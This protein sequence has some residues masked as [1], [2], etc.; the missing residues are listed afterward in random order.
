MKSKSDIDIK[1][2]IGMKNLLFNFTWE[3]IICDE[4]H[5]FRNIKSLLFKCLQLLKGKYKWCFTGTPIVNY[6]NDLISQFVFLGLTPEYR[7]KNQFEIYYPILSNYVNHK[8]YTDC[9][10]VLP[11]VEYNQQVVKLSYEEREFYNLYFKYARDNYKFL[12]KNDQFEHIFSIIMRLRQI[13]ISSYLIL[14]KDQENNKEKPKYLIE[15]D[16]T[17]IG[18]ENI[19]HSNTFD[20]FF[21][22]NSSIMYECPNLNS[23]TLNLNQYKSMNKIDEQIK[24]SINSNSN[25]SNWLNSVDSSAG[26]NSS[27]IKQVIDIVKNKVPKTEKILIFSMFKSVTELFFHAFE[28]NCPEIN[29][30]LFNGDQSLDERNYTINLFKEDPTYRV[31]F[32]TYQTG[33]EGLNIFQANN[34]ILLEG[35]WN[36]SV[37]NQA[38]ARCHRLGQQNK[39][40]VWKL[41]VEDSIEERM[42]AIC[43]RKQEDFDLFIKRNVKKDVFCRDKYVRALLCDKSELESLLNEI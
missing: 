26:Y 1:F 16:K 34:V 43:L 25:M 30:L 2:L 37:E 32:I 19:F 20:M 24:S 4:S 31:L 21:D 9:N 11:P 35:W 7:E 29:Y 42:Q 17:L 27:K 41:I 15:N 38:I 18:K 14:I 6:Y 36:F 40:F 8:T 23:E 33:S 13:C 39:V 5:N 10:I 22:I 12:I 28:F 3:N